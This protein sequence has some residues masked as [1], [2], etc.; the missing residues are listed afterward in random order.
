M[1]PALAM[2]V[3]VDGW[4]NVQTTGDS[5]SP[6]MGRMELGGLIRD[7]DWTL[8]IHERFS[9]TDSSG[10]V[11][12]FLNT[13]SRT[14]LDFSVTA[15]PLTINPEVCWTVDL[16]DN[17]PEIILPVQAGTAY[18]EGFIRPGLGIEADVTENLRLF[19]QGLYWNRDLKQEDD[20]DLAW[21]ETRIS[22]GATWVSPWDVS[23]TVAGLNHKTSS[24]FIG[25]D[26][27]WS[28][29]DVSLGIRPQSLPVNMFL[30]GDVTYSAY[31][32]SDY[33]DHD[34]ADR[35]T[36]RVRVSQMVLSGISV[37]T[38]FESVID[39]DDG[40][41]RSACNSAESRI[42]YRFMKSNDVTSSVVL[43]GKIARSSIRTERAGVF[44]RINI[45]KGLSLLVDAEVRVTPTSVAGAGPNRERYVFGPGL[46]YQFGNT[47]R[48]WGIVEQER[49][50]LVRNENWWRFRAGLE[51]YPGTF[52]F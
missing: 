29:V 38:I 8:V 21:T 44:S 39:F 3:S 24:D 10:I 7:G 25:Y 6:G 36:S 37:N 43:F 35:L 2:A 17:K 9:H 45:Y 28:R 40:V 42:V 20:Y 1:L 49:T 46:E 48:I 22:G 41:T 33:L 47:A 14:D 16:G 52:S 13:Y 27:T 51:L 31:S 23:L 12:R 32:G 18:R 50:D 4:M 15:G 19:A 26:A 34:I 11:P 30:S 5:L